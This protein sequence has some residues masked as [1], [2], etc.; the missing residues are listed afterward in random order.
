MS[1]QEIVRRFVRGIS[2]DVI[3]RE[4]VYSDQNEYDL[5]KLNR[6]DF[7]EKE[8][9]ASEMSALAQSQKQAIY[10]NEQAKRAREAKAAAKTQAPQ[11]RPVLDSLDNTSTDDTRH[12]IN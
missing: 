2:V 7:S 6:M 4:P 3:Q 8:A 12:T 5:E 11:A 9:L 10:A 1:I